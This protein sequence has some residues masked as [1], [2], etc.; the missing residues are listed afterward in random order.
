MSTSF[1]VSDSLIIATMAGE[2]KRRGRYRWREAFV[3]DLAEE[4]KERQIPNATIPL[5]TWWEDDLQDSNSGAEVYTT[6][7]P[8]GRLILFTAGWEAQVWD[9]EKKECIGYWEVHN[10]E[11]WEMR[12]QIQPDDYAESAVEGW[13]GV[14]V[15]YYYDELETAIMKRVEEEEKEVNKAGETTSPTSPRKPEEPRHKTSVKHNNCGRS[16]HQ[17]Q[18]PESTALSRAPASPP[19]S[20]RRFNLAFFPATHI[21]AA[22]RNERPLHP[23]EFDAANWPPVPP[24]ADWAEY[25]GP[26]LANVMLQYALASGLLAV[27]HSESED[28]SGSDSETG[29][30]SDSDSDSSDS[31]DSSSSEDNDIIGV[32][33]SGSDGESSNIGSSEHSN[34]IGSPVSDDDDSDGGQI[35]FDQSGWEAYG[36]ETV[37]P[38]DEQW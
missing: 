15:G 27:D 32:S 30:D 20:T 3:W 24:D 11:A 29:S 12:N 10:N 6:I 1:T 2:A 16:P 21:R 18:A 14:W 31:S 25:D 22:I 23:G 28:E 13:N 8:D 9:W 4:P 35:A 26:E 7:S 33:A 34:E 37:D 5:P 38:D 36:N 17:P 19:P